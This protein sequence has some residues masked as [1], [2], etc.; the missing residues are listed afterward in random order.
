MRRTMKM[1]K[2]YRRSSLVEN[3]KGIK[4]DKNRKRSVIMNFRV[5]PEEKRLIDNRIEQ[6]GV[7]KAD[8]FIHSCLHQTIHVTGN[9]KTFDEM[10]KRMEKIDK[11]LQQVKQSEELEVEV[12]IELRTILELLDNVY[13]KQEEEIS[14]VYE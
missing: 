5:S 13:N 10:K 1:S 6:M 7:R 14:D 2:I 11:R 8:F 12:L 3:V 4:A 9:I